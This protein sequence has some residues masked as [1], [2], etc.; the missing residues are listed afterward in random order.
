[1][2]QEYVRGVNWG[3][4]PTMFNGGNDEISTE[5]SDAEGKEELTSFIG[6]IRM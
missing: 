5:T 3:V 1:M 4:A 2:S 6:K